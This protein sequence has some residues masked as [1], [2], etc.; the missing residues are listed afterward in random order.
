MEKFANYIIRGGASNSPMLY[1]TLLIGLQ[2]GDWNPV[3]LFR[4]TELIKAYPSMIEYSSGTF[5]NRKFDS[6]LRVACCNPNVPIELIRAILMQAESDVT[7][8]KIINYQTENVLGEN[9]YIP[10]SMNAGQRRN[11]ILSLFFEFKSAWND[12]LTAY[13]MGLSPIDRSISSDEPLLYNILSTG[14]HGTFT[15]SNWSDQTT[16]DALELIEAY[17]DLCY[18]SKGKVANRECVS[19]FWMACANPNVPIEII[20][21]MVAVRPRDML[22]DTIKRWESKADNQGKDVYT[23]IDCVQ[24]HPEFKSTRQIL[25]DSHEVK[26]FDRELWDAL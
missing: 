18:Y 23:L 26:L 5:K 7:I 12:G 10:E 14:Y 16:K 15:N 2:T 25:K 6:V 8:S 22:N 19:A 4:A 9:E 17:P 20:Q 1:N 11:E 13:I 24:V 3:A 21:K